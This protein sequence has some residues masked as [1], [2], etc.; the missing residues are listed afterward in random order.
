LVGII[1]AAGT[2][3]AQGERFTTEQP[4]SILIFPK[5]INTNPDT[6]IQITNTTNL[7]THAHCFYVNG[8]V[9]NGQ[10]LWQ[11][12][13]FQIALTRQQPTHW[14]AAQGRQI[15]PLDFNT[16][17]AGIDPGAIPPVAPGFTGYLVC[18][19]TD[20]SGN[21][22]SANSLKGEG[23][24]GAIA[25]AAGVNLASKYNAIGIQAC[26][27]E[28]GCDGTGRANDGDNVLSLDDNEY[29]A[30]PGGVLVNFS[31]EGAADP[32][33]QGAGNVP[34]VVSTN[35]TLVPCGA[36]FENL[37]IPDAVQTFNFRNEFE[38]P[39]SASQV[40]VEC[41]DQVTLDDAVFSD[42]LLIGS[43]GSPFGTGILRP[44]TGANLP[45]VGVANVL[46]V[47]GDGSSD[48]AA[49]NLHFCTEPDAPSSCTTV[50]S[51]IR[52]PTFP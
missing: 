23:T 16:P 8:A 18:V 34:S 2:V 45:V 52:L 7:L 40:P 30:C 22:I 42:Q 28:T 19:E 44:L 15:N 6:I 35:L 29:A 5:V 51:E 12:T 50:N 32:V 14:S 11:V 17:Q 13:D 20:A 25:G 48:T 43:L 36:D 4:A 38:E 31:A 37:I 33:I 21:P 24:V 41:W 1:L 10:A 9:R 47:A 46:R 3:E 27:D 39:G 26:V 49:T